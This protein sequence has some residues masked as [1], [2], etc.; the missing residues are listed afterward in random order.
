[1]RCLSEAR[2]LRRR[3]RALGLGLHRRGGAYTMTRHG[4]APSGAPVRSDLPPCPTLA[5]VGGALR[6]LAAGE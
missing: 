6:A 5:V 1:M 4:V 3:A 2:L